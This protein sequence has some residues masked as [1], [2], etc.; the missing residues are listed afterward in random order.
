MIGDDALPKESEVSN[1]FLLKITFMDR[2]PEYDHVVETFPSDRADQSLD[3]RV[4]PRRSG[5]SRLVPNAY[6]TPHIRKNCGSLL[7][8]SEAGRR[9]AKRELRENYY[10]DIRGADKSNSEAEKALK[11]EI[12][13]IDAETR[14]TVRLFKEAE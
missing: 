11:A 8:Q 10:D 6:G 3:V 5:S 4:L 7:P 13:K 14:K 12:A 9:I 1:P 2:L